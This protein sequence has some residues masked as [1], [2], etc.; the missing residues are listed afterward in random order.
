[1]PEMSSQRSDW[2]ERLYV[3]P[4]RMEELAIRLQEDG[5]Y[6]GI[7]AVVVKSLDVNLVFGKI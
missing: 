6:V 4:S 7:W 2:R 5:V 1:M 3:N